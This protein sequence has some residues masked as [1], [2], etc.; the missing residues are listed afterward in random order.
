MRARFCASA[1]A[2]GEKAAA[3]Q[4]IED[5]TFILQQQGVPDDLKVVFVCCFFVIDCNS[6][7]SADSQFLFFVPSANRLKSKH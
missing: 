7:M 4:A 1:V 2:S 3:K 5:C 6:D